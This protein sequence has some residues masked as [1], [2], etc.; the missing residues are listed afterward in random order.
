M[1]IIFLVL[2][3]I[4]LQAVT[5]P[6]VRA[7]GVQCSLSYRAPDVCVKDVGLQCSLL[8]LPT[9]ST[10]LKHYLPSDTS[11]SESDTDIEGFDTSEYT[12]SQEDTSL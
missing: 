10:P 8:V 6:K 1:I 3:V 7:I 9:T 2:F 5:C 11:Q 12:L 4:G